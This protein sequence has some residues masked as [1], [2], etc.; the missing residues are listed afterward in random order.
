MA[1]AYGRQAQ[2]MVGSLTAAVV[3]G[4]RGGRIPAELGPLRVAILISAIVDGF[5]NA[6]AL[7]G[8]DEMDAMTT[9]FEILVLDAGPE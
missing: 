6:A 8:P 9:L 5:A 7:T 3:R 2:L 4:Q 1:E